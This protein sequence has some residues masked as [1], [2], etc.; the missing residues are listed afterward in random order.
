MKK[1]LLI[2]IIILICSIS[3]AQSSVQSIDFDVVKMAYKNENLT[4]DKVVQTLVVKI[5]SLDRL[6][7]KNLF[8]PADS[9]NLQTHNLLLLLISQLLIV[10]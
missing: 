9:R 3:Y 8:H 2:S 10:D 7:Y 1:V 5:N 6:I 4:N